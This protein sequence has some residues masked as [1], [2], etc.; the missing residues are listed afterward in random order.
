MCEALS[1]PG[2]ETTA[3]GY[4]L[5]GLYWAVSAMTLPSSKPCWITGSPQRRPPRWTAMGG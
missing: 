4:R 3:P 1:C 5:G 2:S